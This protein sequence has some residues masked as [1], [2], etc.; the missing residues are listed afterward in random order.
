LL[1]TT[2]AFGKVLVKPDLASVKTSF[3]IQHWPEEVRT[4][5]LGGRVQDVVP[6]PG[7]TDDSIALYTG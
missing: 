4:L 6:I 5:D 7:H 3:G 1:D 2:L